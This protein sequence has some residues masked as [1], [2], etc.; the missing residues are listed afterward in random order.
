MKMREQTL[1][2]TFL[3]ALTQE[4]V[5]RWF[6]K[7][8]GQGVRSITLRWRTPFKEMNFKSNLIMQQRTIM[9]SNSHLLIKK[10]ID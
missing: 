10:V 2:L 6:Y 5:L 9:K 3:Q 1:S 8:L 4:I 7:T